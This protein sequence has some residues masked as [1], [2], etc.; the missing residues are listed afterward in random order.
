MATIKQRINITVGE[1]IEGALKQAAKR[2]RV[3]VASKAAELLE[4]ALNLEEDM[5]L[6]RLAD[7][8]MA[9]KVRFISHAKAWK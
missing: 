9:K 8:R 2:D 4:L 6:S 7:E 3:P 5:A 1:T